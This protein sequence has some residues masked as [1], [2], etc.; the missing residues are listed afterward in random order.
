[1][2]KQT[3]KLFVG[4]YK[5]RSTS[6]GE[7]ESIGFK[8]EDLELMLKHC[9]GGWVNIDLKQSKDGKK[10]MEI[11]TYQ[12]KGKDANTPPP[13]KDEIADREAQIQQ[14]VEDD[15]LPF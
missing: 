10:Y 15:E 13:S 4:N 3:E 2:A 12:P 5:T 14:A 1:M 7:I 9:T 6:F 11:N 8:K